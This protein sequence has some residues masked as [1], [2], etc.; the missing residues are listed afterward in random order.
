MNAYAED[1]FPIKVNEI[2]ESQLLTGQQQQQQ[3]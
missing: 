3:Q 2:L 1:D